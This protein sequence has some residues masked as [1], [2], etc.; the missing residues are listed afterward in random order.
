MPSRAAAVALLVIAAGLG[1]AA[2]AS[3]QERT[4]GS[5]LAQAPN[6]F[7]C[8][9]RPTFTEQSI[10]GDYFFLPSNLPDCTWFQSGVP[11]SVDYSDPRTG[12][13][14]ANG[15]ITNI[16]VRSGPNPALMSFVILRQLAQPGTGVACCFFVRETPLVRPA[17]NSVTNFTVNLPVERNVNPQ[18]AIA[19]ADYVGV[20][21]VA[22][23]GLLPLFGN[24]QHNTLAHS[25]LPGNPQAGFLYPRLG[26]SPGDS[27][28]GRREEGIP[29]MEVLLRWTWCPAGQTCAPVPGAQPMP[30]DPGGSGGGGAGGGG[31]PGGGAGNSGGASAGA[32]SLTGTDGPDQLCGLGGDDTIDGLAGDDT[33]FGDACG[34]TARAIVAAGAGDGKD[35]LTGGAGKD[36]LYGAG[37]NDTLSGGAA[38]D[39]LFGGAGNDKLT[40]GAGTNRYSG[41]AGADKISARNRKRER[42]DC[43]KGRDTATVDRHDK[44][45]GCEKVRRARR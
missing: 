27:G 44:V 29:G 10:N 28:G 21:A 24:G 41:G 31:E 35:K 15:T 2:P 34:A 18:T 12:S 14:P 38:N 36:T 43:G 17:A 40:G 42:I 33:I 25:S 20:S 39:K 13:V 45:K 3:A 19:T 30:S 7:G 6:T 5:P 16:A 23:S 26:A 8:E 32:D 1:A 4:L 9:T 22:G 37:G 11:G